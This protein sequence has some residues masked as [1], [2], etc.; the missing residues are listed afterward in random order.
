MP[1]GERERLDEMVRAAHVVGSAIRFYDTPDDRGA[2]RD[3]VWRELVAADVDYIS[4]DDLAGFGAFNRGT[5][6]SARLSSQSCGRGRYPG[7]AR[8]CHS[9]S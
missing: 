6:A 4:T 2:A 3:A 8:K 5:P 9:G 1:S 7:P